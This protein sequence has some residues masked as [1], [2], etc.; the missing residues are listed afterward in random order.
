MVPMPMRSAS[1]SAAR[2]RSEDDGGQHG[3]GRDQAGV[4]LVDHAAHQMSLRDV[5]GFVGHHAREFILVA[6]GQEQ[7]AVDHDE[8]ARH[9]ERV[10]HRIAHDRVVELVLAFLGVAREAV[11]DLLNVIADLGVL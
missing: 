10:D 3:R 7:P 4:R 6:R 2:G 11:A 8:A 1:N 9:R 5:G